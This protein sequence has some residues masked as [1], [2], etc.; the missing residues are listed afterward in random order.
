LGGP[1]AERRGVP[2]Y[3]I[4]SLAELFRNIVSLIH[5]KLLIEYLEDLATLEVRHGEGD[6]RS[7]LVEVAKE[8]AK[9]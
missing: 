5:N 9:V 8:E 1:A 3:A 7:S 2:N 6:E 4:S